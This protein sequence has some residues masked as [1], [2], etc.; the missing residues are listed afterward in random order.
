MNGDDKT[1]QRRSFSL[2][3]IEPLLRETIARGSSFPMTAHGISMLPLIR[4]GQDVVFLSALPEALTP[5]DIIL[6]KRPDGQYVLHRLM[7]IRGDEFLFCGDHQQVFERGIKKDALIA[8]AVALQKNGSPDETVDFL[9]D[10]AYLAYQKTLLKEKWRHHR[11]YALH[12]LIHDL[13][14]V[15]HIK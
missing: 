8:R 2:C 11:L 12:R 13:L 14:H 7:G 5:G 10:E 9:S 6:Y 15:L 3:D 4:D 1:P